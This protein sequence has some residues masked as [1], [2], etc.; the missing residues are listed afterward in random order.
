M[1]R[2]T[3]KYGVHFHDINVGFAFDAEATGARQEKVYSADLSA[4]E[5]KKLEGLGKD[6][7]AEYG[8]AKDDSKPAE[9]AE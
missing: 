9:D 6:V 1:A 3:S 4:A 5:A 2:Y 7:L 8:I